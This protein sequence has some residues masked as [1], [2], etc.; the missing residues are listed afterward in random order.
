MRTLVSRWTKRT[1]KQDNHKEKQDMSI[2]LSNLSKVLIKLI[3]ISYL[4]AISDLGDRLV[5]GM[6]L[7]NPAEGMDVSL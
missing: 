4:T 3:M 5:A 2:A 1:G 7:S 6:A